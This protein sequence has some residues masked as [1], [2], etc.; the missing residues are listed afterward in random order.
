MY[1]EKPT[2]KQARPNKGAKQEWAAGKHCSNSHLP[3]PF[4][5]PM[6][7]AEAVA[8]CCPHHHEAAFTFHACCDTGV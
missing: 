1:K 7:A 3:Q 2:A 4:A 6:T 5:E 8:L